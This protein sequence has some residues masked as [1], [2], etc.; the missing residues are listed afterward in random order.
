MT[1]T[2]DFSPSS[3]VIYFIPLLIL[4]FILINYKSSHCPLSWFR[5]GNVIFHCT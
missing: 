5:L 4:L 2:S 3:L 1:R